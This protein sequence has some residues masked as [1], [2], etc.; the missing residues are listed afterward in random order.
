MAP[1][2]PSRHVASPHDFGRKR[3]I[4][5]I[6][7]ITPVDRCGAIDPFPTILKKSTVCAELSL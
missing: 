2:G 4:A 5:D 6:E 7:I 1:Y 3:G